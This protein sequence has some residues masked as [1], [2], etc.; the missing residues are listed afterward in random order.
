MP[1]LADTI[2]QIRKRRG[3]TMVVFAKRL[4]VTHPT[5]SG[6]ES[7][8]ITPSRSMLLLLLPLADG[9]ER[10]PILASLD[11]QEADRSSLPDDEL[12]HALESFESWFSSGGFESVDRSAKELRRG[13]AEFALEILRAPNAPLI[14][15]INLVLEKWIRHR[16]AKR[17]HHVFENAALYL[18]IELR[19]FERGKPKPAA[20]RSGV[21]EGVD[22]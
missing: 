18:D 14:P 11:L 8:K 2:R 16:S 12:Q 4:G 20:Q 6:Y 10:L 17:T 22:E 19:K 21:E 3:E 9:D 5:I 13:F 7:G 1:T 15:G